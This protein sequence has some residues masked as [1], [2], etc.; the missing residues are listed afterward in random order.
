[1]VALVVLAGVTGATLCAPSALAASPL[2]WSYPTVIDAARVDA[3]SCPSVSFCVGADTAGDVLDSTDP[4]GGAAAWT[5]A[6]VDQVTPKPPYFTDGLGD[7]SC[8]APA[9]SLCVAVGEQGI[10]ASADPTAG[11]GAWSWAGAVGAG[12]RAVSC[13][14]TSLCVVAGSSYSGEILTSTEPDGGEGAWKSVKV[15]G[16]T[17]IVAIS[18]PTETLCVGVDFNG[19]VLSS[20]DPT[21]GAGTWSITSVGEVDSVSCPTA[22]FCVATGGLRAVTSTHPTGGNAAWTT[23][24]Q[25][26]PASNTIGGVACASPSLCIAGDDGVVWESMDP[27]GGEA[28]WGEQSGLDGNNPLGAAACA[29]ESLCFVADEALL[30]GVP[31]HRL[32]VS[33]QGEG[34]VGS[35]ALACPYGCT[36]SGSTCPRDCAEPSH[37]YIPPRLIGI[38]CHESAPFGPHNWGTCEFAFPAQNTVTLTPTPEPGWVF[39]GWSGSCGGASACSLPMD[40]DRQ[41]TAS[42]APLSK[43]PPPPS[44]VLP[45]LTDVH[46]T[47]ARWRERHRVA[48]AHIRPPAV[49]TDFR[50]ALGR[51]AKVTLAFVRTQPGSMIGTTC[52]ERRPGDGR[53]RSTGRK[54]GTEHKPGAE[55][56]CTRRIPAGTLD[57]SGHAGHNEV[58]FDGRIHG[59]RPLQPGNYTLLITARADGASAHGQLH[60]QIVR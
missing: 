21:G 22:S 45:L 47:H 51:P 35:G 57:F 20:T 43:G 39:A 9:G 41:V 5:I 4:T 49:G 7:V 58:R 23:Q 8:P 27:S 14:S 42:F 28:A 19:N 46:Q 34:F 25:G 15:D 55:H 54:Q 13:P 37:A 29:S 24:V 40:A 56:P 32:A 3:L 36:Y 11:A 44:T 16:N 38:A 18:C 52:V 31:T 6:R 59:H 2:Y 26:G 53:G 10:F 33:I 1:M 17:P 60:F 12:A 50:F 30:I 48:G